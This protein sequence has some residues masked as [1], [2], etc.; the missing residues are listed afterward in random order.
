MLQCD[1]RERRA[2]H[3]AFI[4]ARDDVEFLSSRSE[5]LRLTLQSNL[6]QRL[7]TVR[8]KTRTNDVNAAH[9]LLTPLR[10]RRGGVGFEPLGAAEAGFKAEL[11]LVGRKPQRL[12]Q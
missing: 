10:E 7:Q 1:L 12:G 5:E 4:E 11:V 3:G 2:P 8:D 9:P 6:L